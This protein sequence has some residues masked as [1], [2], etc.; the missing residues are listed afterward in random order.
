[1][2]TLFPSIYQSTIYRYSTVL[3]YNPTVRDRKLIGC[4]LT[5]KFSKY[6][7]IDLY[8]ITVFGCTV[9]YIILKDG[10]LRFT[11]FNITFKRGVF[12]TVHSVTLY[13]DFTLYCFQSTQRPALCS[14]RLFQTHRSLTSTSS[15]WKASVTINVLSETQD[16]WFLHHGTLQT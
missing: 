6:I 14:K 8:Q 12:F 13:V 7:S 2:F 1:M 9:Q 10:I 5:L 4:N 16:Y 3:V 15:R 11:S